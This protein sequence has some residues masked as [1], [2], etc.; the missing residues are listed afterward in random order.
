MTTEVFR[1]NGITVANIHNDSEI[2]LFGIAALS[3]SNYERPD[4]AGISHFAEHLF[5][6]GTQKRNWKQINEEFAKLGVNN[7]AY[8]SNT[9]VFYHTTCPKE[10]IANVIDL[11]TDMFFNSTYLEEEIEKERSV[12]I[13]EKKMYDDDPKSAFLNMLGENFFTWHLGHETIGTF[14]TI[15]NIKKDNIVSYLR[16]KLSPSNFIFICSGNVDSN[17]LRRY[18]ENS[19]PSSHNYF[20]EKGGINVL[21]KGCWLDIVNSNDKIKFIVERENITQS[22]VYMM[23][24]GIP[25]TD[26]KHHAASIICE[27]L[28]GG[29]YSKLFSRIREELGLCYSVGMYGIPMS[30]PDKKIMNVYGYTSPENVDKFIDEAEKV[31]DDIVKN[32]LDQNIFQCAKTDYISSIL[33][34]TE[35]SAGKAHFMVNKLL[36]EKGGNLED[37]IAEMRAVTIKDCN[38]LIPVMMKNKHNW[39]VMNPKK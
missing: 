23:M 38:E 27:A 29:M 12:I 1:V 24:D 34:A 35:T 8:T 28:G 36:V 13:E 10:N 19:M 33:R 4:I 21:E 18:L 32:G 9:E 16:A 39:A 15:K 30:Y 11:M 31:I 14:D 20:V 5:F 25:Y 7:N 6:K 22:I 2:V 17:D 37:T 26:P 3:G